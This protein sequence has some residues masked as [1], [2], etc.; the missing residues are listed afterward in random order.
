MKEERFWEIVAEI[1]WPKVDCDSAKKAFMQRYDQTVAEGF[2]GEFLRLKRQLYDRAGLTAISDSCDDNLAHIIGLGKD[3]YYRC[4]ERPLLV[5][6]REE[7]G[8]YQ[9]SFAYCIPFEHDY[10]RLT[11]D[12]YD[13]YLRHVAELRQELSEADPDDVAPRLYRRFPDVIRVCDL[14]LDRRWSEAVGLYHE[15]FGEGYAKDWPDLG[16][17]VPNCIKDLE[18][19]RL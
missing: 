12:G 17:A 5:R 18:R 4:M 8:D 16:Y 3:E 7:N 6:E 15:V 14:L 9:E 1:G 19:Y 10:G 13:T 11:D 2:C